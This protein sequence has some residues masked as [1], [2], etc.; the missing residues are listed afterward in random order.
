[1]TSMPGSQIAGTTIHCLFFLLPS[2]WETDWFTCCF[3][4]S[5]VFTAGQMLGCWLC[6]LWWGAVIDGSVSKHSLGV[7]CKNTQTPTSCM[8]NTHDKHFTSIVVISEESNCFIVVLNSTLPCLEVTAGKWDHVCEGNERWVHRIWFIAN[9][10][11]SSKTNEN[12][13]TKWIQQLT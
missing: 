10:C 4:P 7:T 5:W 1:M 2:R 11:L 3:S 13:D 8:L 6:R 12:E 9:V